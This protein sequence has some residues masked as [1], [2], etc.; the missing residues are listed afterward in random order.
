[1][2]QLDFVIV[3]AMDHQTDSSKLAEVIVMFIKAVRIQT[4]KSMTF[5]ELVLAEFMMNRRI[6]SSVFEVVVIHRQ[7][8]N[9]A[10]D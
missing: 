2:L 8:V 1:M 9:F 3:V 5:K 4:K 6:M 10:V 7:K